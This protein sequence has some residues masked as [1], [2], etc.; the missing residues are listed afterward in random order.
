MTKA[1]E[2]LTHTNLSIKEIAFA[3]GYTANPNFYRDFLDIHGLTPGDFRRLSNS[4]PQPELLHEEGEIP[5]AATSR[6]AADWESQFL[7][8]PFRRHPAGLWRSLW[9]QPHKRRTDL[10]E[11]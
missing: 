5:V 6:H 7:I 3:S 2:L 10:A 8:L 1:A 11:S 4:L 9:K